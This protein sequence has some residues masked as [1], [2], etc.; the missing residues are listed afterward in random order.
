LVVAF[1]CVGPVGAAAAAAGAG[2]ARFR[3][4]LAADRLRFRRRVRLEAFGRGI[5]LGKVD[6]GG[7]FGAHVAGAHQ[8]G[9]DRFHLLDDVLLQRLDIFELVRVE[10]LAVLVGVIREQGA[11]LVDDGDVRRW[12]IRDRRRHQV[13]DGADLRPVERA[14]RLQ[15]QQYR[16]GRL[17]L[18]AH[19]HG[20]F[21]Q[22]QVHAC[23]RDGGQRLDRV[24]QFAF[25]RALVIDLFDELRSAQFLV[26]QQFEADIAGARQALLRQLQAHVVHALG[27]HHDRIAA[28]GK[29]V[30]D[31]HLVERRGDGAAILVGVVRE[32]HAVVGRRRP[33]PQRRHHGQHAGNGAA[34]DDALAHR[35]LP[36]LG[37]VVGR[38]RA[39][40]VEKIVRCGCHDGVRE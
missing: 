22:R 23:R 21:R 15:V 27:R 35:G 6:V 29:L 26:F 17:L 13:H 28:V 31:A 30:L 36:E 40:A 34:D 18:L 1:F 14:A 12:Q 16:C 8:R 7:G 38:S 39:V 33:Q 19:E 37:L 2:A 32:Q 3:R 10:L 9:D 11:V 20:R 5:G 24:G 25:Q 4:L